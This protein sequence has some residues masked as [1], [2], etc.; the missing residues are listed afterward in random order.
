M[1][2]IED[3]KKV[4]MRVGTI[5]ETAVNEKARKPAYKLTIDLGELGIKKTSAQITNVYKPEDL[6]NMQVIVVTNFSPMKIG[7]VTSEVLVLGVDTKD[8]VVLLNL[9]RQVENGKRVY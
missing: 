2:T 1:I 6:I 9:E 8:G 3:F 5:I 7:D 4:D